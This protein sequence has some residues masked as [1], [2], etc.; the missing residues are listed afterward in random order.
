MTKKVN[1][2][3]SLDF[4]T[5]LTKQQVPQGVSLELKKNET[6]IFFFYLMVRHY[7]L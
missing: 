4:K 7:K 3:F 2:L 5:M 1:Y 6:P